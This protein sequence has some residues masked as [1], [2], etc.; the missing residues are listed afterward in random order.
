MN[1]KLFPHEFVFNHGNKK[2]I[3]YRKEFRAAKRK[4]VVKC[5]KNY[6]FDEKKKDFRE[7]KWIQTFSIDPSGAWLCF[8]FFFIIKKFNQEK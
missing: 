6:A 4:K 7:S 2:L 8:N 1:H 3:N 5:I